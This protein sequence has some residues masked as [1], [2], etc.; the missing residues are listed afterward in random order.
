M[1]Q[2]A[3]IL[4]C[5]LA[6][7]FYGQIVVDKKLS[8]KE[9]KQFFENGTI[10][11]KKVRYSGHRRAIGTFTDYDTIFDM[12]QGLVLSTGG[13]KY[14]GGE[15]RYGSRSAKNRTDGHEGLSKICG[16]ETKDAA[17][18]EIDFIPKSRFISFNYVFGSDEYPEFVRSQFNDAFAFYL[19]KRGE[20]S[21][22]LAVIPGTN[23]RIS[24]NSVN[25]Y[26][27]SQYFVNNSF[28]PFPLKAERSD[29]LTFVKDGILSYSVKHYHVASAVAQNPKIPVEFD[30]F[31]RLL[32]AKAR[33]EPGQL[34]TL[35]ICIADAS[36]MIY[37]SGVL[38]EA[39]SLQSHEQEDFRY[40]LLA[41]DDYYFEMDT[42]PVPYELVER[43]M[44]ELGITM[45]A[46][47]TTTHTNSLDSTK[48]TAPIAKQAPEVI[49]PLEL[50]L[51]YPTDVYAIQLADMKKLEATKSKLRLD[52]FYEVTIRG[53]T[54]Q[55]AS[56]IY[57]K[58][59][60]E[61]RAG[62]VEDF[63]LKNFPANVVIKSTIGEG[64]HYNTVLTKSDKRSTR[65]VFT[66]VPNLEN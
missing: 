41:S 45:E 12:H 39:G 42:V 32:Q 46:M 13:V 27:Q 64:I 10:E 20:S 17:I 37:D 8:K 60:S 22:N 4:A 50:I 58:R 25:F 47:E 31:T 2:A 5:L 57:N 6:N 59:L 35:E 63:I 43:E 18:V 28:L 66:P 11:I 51:H 14:I 52:H 53:Y 34:Y 9:I 48:P 29:T 40:G 56:S 33:V 61:R 19:H 21:T 55:D 1:K 23:S 49:H 3:F 36:D 44:R 54:D 24:I 62:T 7:S 15:N 65:I 38:I 30:G 16:V 26:T